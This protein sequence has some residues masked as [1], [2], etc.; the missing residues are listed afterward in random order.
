MQNISRSSQKT[1]LST[2]NNQHQISRQLFSYKETGHKVQR[3]HF[4]DFSEYTGW[5]A[6]LTDPFEG[7]SSSSRV[8]ACGKI[9]QM[10]GQCS[11]SLPSP[12]RCSWGLRT[13]PSTSVMTFS[14]GAQGGLLEYV[15]SETIFVPSKY[16]IKELTP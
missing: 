7:N 10:L 15:K 12:I 4:K 3:V 13:H 11:E 9:L 8:S 14:S 6:L 5:L 1:V 2:L 16:A